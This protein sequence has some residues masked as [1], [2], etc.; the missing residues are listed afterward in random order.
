MYTLIT[1]L[2]LIP[3]SLGLQNGDFRQTDGGLAA[4][5]R[6]IGTYRVV[7][8][9]GRNGLPA[10]ELESASPTANQ[11]ALQVIKF[12]PPRK[13]SFVVTAWVKCENVRA[14]GDCTLWLD[15]LQSGGKPIW[16]VRGEP[17]RSSDQWQQVRAEVRPDHPVSELQVFLIL[18]GVTGKVR[19][20]DVKAEPLSPQVRDI[21]LYPTAPGVY[22]LR[23]NLSDSAD[24][25]IDGTALKGTGARVAE[26]IAGPTA[27]PLT[28]TLS[29]TTE[30]GTA[31][32]TATARPRAVYPACD[33][34]A[35]DSFT[36]VFQDDLPPEEPAHSVTLDAARNDRESFQLCLRPTQEPMKQVQVEASELRSGGYSIP[37]SRIE[38]FRV[39]YLHMKS[40]FRHPFSPRIG[41]TWWP[42]PLLPACRFDVDAGQVQP[43]W[44]TVHVPKDTA[45]GNYKGSITVTPADRPAITVPVA[46]TVHPAIIPDQ[47]HMKTAF[48]L[49]DHFLGNL[50]GK[51]TPE[52]R[53][54]YTDCLLAHHLNPDDIS[55]TQPPDLDDLA[56]AGKHG[57]NAL[58]ILNVVPEPKTPGIV[59]L[60]DL[61]EY[62][63]EFK[64][65]F[66]ERL[67]RIVPEIEKLGLIDRAYIYGFDERG[68]EFIPVIRDIFAEIKKRYPKVHTC[69]TCWP[70]SGTDPLSLNVDWYVQLSSSYDHELAQSVRKRGGEV[71][72]YVCCGPNYPYANWL[73][74]N[75]LIEAR[76][77]FWQAFAH[78]VEGFLYW[79]VNLWWREHND[80]L[81]PSTAGPRLDFSVTTGGDLPSLNGDGVLLYPGED[82]PIG[83]IR[84]EN[85]RDGL[86]DVELLYAYKQRFGAA[87]VGEI[88][89][90]VTTSRTVYSRNPRDLLSA[91]LAMLKALK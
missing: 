19:F 44:F 27:S 21:R 52:L 61:K 2:V 25:V 11:S 7:P 59:I 5:W 47:G 42:E 62:T 80:K 37:R 38:W 45:P 30:D 17:D 32:A 22:D 60:A 73:I 50:Y 43:V 54:K 9:G 34:W 41:P 66:F 79:C 36:R 13:G 57:L 4:N 10:L 90:K 85:I 49:M 51:I 14:G 88:M 29:A 6:Q 15:V 87:R 3:A 53:R 55:R 26:R 16:G 18:R 63:P 35:A 67:D 8:N 91:R 75:P 28:V 69:S 81:I 20:C 24:W 84:L 40:P 89:K 56:Y 82:G 71:W 72:W 46:L 58:N 48:A 86:E 1:A 68:P 74:E 70:P 78:D 64:Q 31:T 12:D 33:W 83:S 39:G 77:V 76:S 65:R 23:A